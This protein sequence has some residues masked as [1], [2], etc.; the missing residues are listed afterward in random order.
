MRIP[1]EP[2]SRPP[3]DK[4]RK[5]REEA[6]EEEEKP[7]PRPR[8][9]GGRLGVWLV[10]TLA[11]LLLVGGGIGVAAW[12]LWGLGDVS[13]DLYLV[14]GDAHG[15]ATLRVRDVWNSEAT[16]QAQAQRADRQRQLESDFGLA[17]AD[18][19]RL[20]VGSMEG[21][22]DDDCF[23]V[24][25]FAPYDRKKLAMKQVGGE[26]K[27]G[28]AEGRS[29]LMYNEGGAALYYA[30]DRVFVTGPEA[31]LKRCLA[32]ANRKQ[33]DGPLAEPLKV[34]DAGKHQIVAGFKPQELASPAQLDRLPAGLSSSV[35]S[36]SAAESGTIT[37]DLSSGAEVELILGYADDA[38]AD[39][40][41][42]GLDNLI[43]TGRNTVLPLAKGQI[44]AAPGGQDQGTRL[45][46]SIEDLLKTLAAEQNGSTVSLKVRLDGPTVA[47][48]VAAMP[49]GPQFQPPEAPPG[50]G[51]GR[52]AAP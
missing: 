46:K 2:P 24:R 40:G 1:G 45:Y 26:P 10:L 7:A 6:P 13:N 38:R 34:A 35:K 14:P 11:S 5:H 17:P 15:F 49:T 51:P 36:L 28:K 9:K 29:Y 27:S 19:E 39:A 41:K 32:Q 31:S 30:S 8:K 37:A 16:Q 21:K 43:R 25:T 4:P 44:V 52:G 42:K 12:Y 20:T 50:R 3:D 18:I 33:F 48:V 22:K 47:A 23:I